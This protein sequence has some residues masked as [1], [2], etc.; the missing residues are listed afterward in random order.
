MTPI[1]CA[2]AHASSRVLKK[3]LSVCAESVT[4][5]VSG[6]LVG[7]GDAL[8][9]GTFA[10]TQHIALPADDIRV[11]VLRM[12]IS[13]TL[14]RII[15]ELTEDI[16]P[17]PVK[18]IRRWRSLCPLMRSLAAKNGVAPARPPTASSCASPTS[19][20]CE[21]LARKCPNDRELKTKSTN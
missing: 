10:N 12:F 9:T 3:L 16:Y 13:A 14:L 21:Q 11:T 15:L 5:R 8:S 18:A 1:R 20:L 7:R 17:R 6:K 2:R 4:L 19:L